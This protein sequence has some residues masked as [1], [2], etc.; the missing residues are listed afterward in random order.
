MLS[1]ESIIL[2]L[3]IINIFLVFYPFLVYP[4]V[5]YIISLFKKQRYIINNNSKELPELTVVIAAYNEEK[6]IT[7][8]ILSLYK[9]GYDHNKLR[10]IV[11]I[12]G[13]TDNT[14]LEINKL[15]KI[16]PNI[17]Y[18][19]LEHRGKN[20]VLNTIIPKV[21]TCYYLVMDA[22]MRVKENTLVKMVVP[23]MLNEK[24]GAVLANMEKINI[25]ENDT[26]NAGSTGEKI[27]QKFETFL[28]KKES[29]I[30]TTV[31][32]FGFIAMR[33]DEFLPIPN[34]FMCDDF[35]AILKTNSMKK[36]VFFIDDLYVQE[37][38]RQS[39][40]GEVNRRQRMIA[41]SLATIK[42]YK[43]LLLPN[44]GFTSF[45]LWSHKCLRY[46]LP[47]YLIIIAITSIF[48]PPSI[49]RD[50]LIYFQLCF[51]LMSIIAVILEKN[52]IRMLLFK[53]LSFFLMMN[54]SCILGIFRFCFG[55]QNSSWKRN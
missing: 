46:L 39:L 42:Y 22:D 6:N 51:Y 31:N 28:R 19:I 13:K 52:G 10:V 16:Y 9:D 1:L 4:V 23:L 54:Y 8:A 17:E 55:R 36:N 38:S 47:L 50:F 49:F 35:F 21:K 44:Y 2:C 24:I 5:L 43:K 34:D 14:D 40:S 48:I 45:A 41:G 32:A 53:I 33:R 26:N 15:Q 25:S 12:D 3:L 29:N 11:G 18:Y 30:R 20:A 7:D 37:I 27:Y